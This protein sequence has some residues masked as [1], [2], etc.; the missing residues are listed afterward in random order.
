MKKLTEEQEELRDSDLDWAIAEYCWNAQGRNIWHDFSPT[1][2]W[3][4][5]GLLIEKYQI[6]IRYFNKDRNPTLEFEWMGGLQHVSNVTGLLTYYTEFG[7]TPLIAAMKAL[8]KAL[9]K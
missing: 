1:T 6:D 8:A 4:E 3:V 7:P 2:N 9:N 5:A